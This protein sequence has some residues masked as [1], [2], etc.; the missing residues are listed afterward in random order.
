M[1][2]IWRYLLRH[3]VQVF[4]L[5]V[6]SFVA[7]LLVLRFQDIARFATAGTSQ[8]HVLLFA[9]LQIPYIVPIAIPISSLIAGLLLFQRLSDNHE[10]TAF[11]TSG[12]SLSSMA[13]PLVFA[14]LF[15]SL[16]NWTIVSEVAP[17][18]RSASKNLVYHAVATNPLL[19]FQKNS[20]IKFRN[21]F[22]DIKALKSG[23]SAEEVAFA[24]KNNTGE[25]LTLLM[26]KKLFLK[27]SLLKGEQVSLISSAD[28]QNGNSAFDHLIIENQ[29]AMDTQASYLS[30]YTQN[31]D[32][33]A[34]Y[35]YSSLKQILTREQ[36]KAKEDRP[37]HLGKKARLEI[38]K[39][40][41]LAIAALSFT[42]IGIACGTCIG[43]NRSRKK[44]LWALSL[45][46]FY[47][48]C[49]IAAKSLRHHP[50]TAT[51]IYLGPHLIILLICFRFLK[52]TERGIS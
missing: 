29:S 4:I 44:G 28:S 10:L 34:T 50:S 45:A 21:A 33:D 51:W 37:A 6:G 5:C 18:S 11:R 15:L 27:G 1:P 14:G 48:I 20:P 17:R 43:R 9:L 31:A 52:T 38:A 30:Q 7:M 49:F 24:I 8:I 39:R 19:L 26:A 47:L 40:L 16:L 32:W 12:I 23:K 13:L 35:E 2:I 42:C 41:S 25:R 22:I 46:A 36:A 3:F